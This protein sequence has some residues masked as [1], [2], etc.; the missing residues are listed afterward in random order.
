MTC[1]FH[2]WTYDLD[3][4]L[5]GLPGA[6]GFA[7]MDRE[8]RSLRRVGVAEWGGM[9]FIRLNSAEEIDVPAHLGSFADELL[10]LELDRARPMKHSR[11]ECRA[12]WKY[13]WDT[14]CENYH[15]GTLHAATVAP[16]VVSN[17]AVMTPYG[18]HA[19][20]G[21]LRKDWQ[22]LRELDE[23]QWPPSNYG[24]NY[25][26]FPNINLNVSSAPNGEPFYGFYH[27]YPGT[28][29]DQ[30]LTRMATYRPAHAAGPEPDEDWRR[31]H[32]FIENVVVTEDYRVAAEG[33]R[34]LQYMPSSM[35]TIIG[36]NEIL[37]QKWHRDWAQTLR[38]LGL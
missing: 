24:G 19:R 32:D 2:G 23:S 22:P 13:A 1:P 4:R 25:F 18:R 6:D 31:L 20:M 28:Q 15:F 8:A 34:N 12:N 36:A 16:R 29:P 37:V 26:I 30:C 35:R 11:V 3:G 14:Y 21:F 27:L 17:M 33:Q 5:T 9:I 10:H 38:E 7:D